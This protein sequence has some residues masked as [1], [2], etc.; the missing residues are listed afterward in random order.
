M[1]WI[2]DPW[3]FKCQ[4]FQSYSRELKQIGPRWNDVKASM[5]LVLIAQNYEDLVDM[6]EYK[7]CVTENLKTRQNKKNDVE[8]KLAKNILLET[9][10]RSFG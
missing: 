6:A 1:Q 4:K 8:R 10:D 5:D 9:R 2:R 7:N 3:I